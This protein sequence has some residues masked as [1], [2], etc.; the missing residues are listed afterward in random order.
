MSSLF[1]LFKSF[2]FQN[3]L[4][5]F[6]KVFETKNE[7]D[8]NIEARL[9]FVKNSFNILNTLLKSIDKFLSFTDNVDIQVKENLK[10]DEEISREMFIYKYINDSIREIRKLWDILMKMTYEYLKLQIKNDQFAYY[11]L[12]QE[13]L[14]CIHRY[15]VSINLVPEKILNEN[16]KHL[17]NEEDKK[18][19][20]LEDRYVLEIA[21]KLLCEIDG[22]IETIDNILSEEL[23]SKKMDNFTYVNFIFK[24]F[25]IFF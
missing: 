20:F 17:S 25:F 11:F 23:S 8:M 14:Y 6:N 15:I 5:S 12:I 16:R 4:D 10:D 1:Y 7:K 18:D 22:A 13:K 2:R 9:H 21:P 3:V 24:F 19:Q